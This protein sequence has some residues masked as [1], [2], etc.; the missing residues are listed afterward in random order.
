MR[1]GGIDQMAMSHALL[2]EFDHEMANTRKTLERVPEDKFEWRP[3][4]KSTTMG[5]LAVHLAQIPATAGMALVNDS[6][7][8]NPPGGSGYK[9]PEVKTREGLLALFD[10]N[11]ASARA[12]IAGASDEQF[13][14]SWSLLNG[15]KVLFTLP[16]VAVLRSFLMNHSIH[17]RAQL[18]VYLRLNNVPVP[19]IYGPSADESPF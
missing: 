14:Q 8:V 1:L 17:H 6:L 4:E 13:L 2:P 19:S 3:H 7:D 18:G 9:L 16:R 15:G 12:T 10:K 5:N 11:V